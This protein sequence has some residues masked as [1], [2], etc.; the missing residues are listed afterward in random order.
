MDLLK[1]RSC[2]NK[3]IVVSI[4]CNTFN[5]S[6]YLKRALDSFLNQEVY[7]DVEILIHDDCSNDCT[8]SIIEEYS[9]RYPNIIKPIYE[10]E[11]QYSKGVDILLIQSKRIN[12]KYVALCEGDDYW[13]DNR[14]LVNQVEMLEKT[15]NKMCVHK[16]AKCD[17]LTGKQIGSI[18]D[19]KLFTGTIC[20]NEFL[21]IIV[22]KYS[23]QTSSYLLDAVEFRKMYSCNIK[24]I[25]LMPTG[26][27]SIM[28]Y[29]A[30][31]SDIDYIDKTMSVYSYLNKGSWS[32]KFLNYTNIQV[33][34]HKKRCYLAYKEYDKFTHKKYHHILK[35]RIHDNKWASLYLSKR[36]ISL[37][38]YD[39][40]GVLSM[41][42]NHFKKEKHE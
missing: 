34:K 22:D 40:K 32:T 37:F 27:E 36:Y 33:G 11:N 39:P 10:K 29:F 23:F 14:K 9:K 28:L 25:Q 41:I 30:S 24:F 3:N 12:G 38:F 31:I 7:F 35:R 15:N 13:C 1:N 20:K 21:S 19:L 26:D 6:K 4:I 16:V 5:H 8:I 17:S 42:K 18:P 2:E